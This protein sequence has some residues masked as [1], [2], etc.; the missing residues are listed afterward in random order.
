M[1]KKYNN[2]LL[3]A[4]DIVYEITKFTFKPA[5]DNLI[6]IQGLTKSCVKK[7]NQALK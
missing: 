4:H 1:T 3:T 2:N 5:H 6:I 7:K